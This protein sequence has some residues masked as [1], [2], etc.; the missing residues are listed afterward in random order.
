ME[1][2]AVP[3]YLADPELVETARPSSLLQVLRVGEKNNFS[4]L[5]LYVL[6]GFAN[7]SDRESSKAIDKFPIPLDKDG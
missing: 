4:P 6:A 5:S 1:L 7:G 2:I 3:K